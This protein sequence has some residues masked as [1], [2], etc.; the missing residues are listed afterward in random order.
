MAARFYHKSTPQ[1]VNAIVNANAVLREAKNAS[2]L[3]IVTGRL[4]WIPWNPADGHTISDFLLAAKNMVVREEGTAA[5]PISFQYTWWESPKY[6][7]EIWMI[8]SFLLVGVMWPAML[9]VM[10][11]GGL[12]PDY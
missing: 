6:V 11:K 1:G 10:V 4:Y 8:G 2:E 9:R 12:G 7:Y 5:I 3:K